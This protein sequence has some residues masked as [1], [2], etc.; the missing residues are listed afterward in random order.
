MS[1][2]SSSPSL[3]WGWR[4]R[5][6]VP[7]AHA[8]L[9][10]GEGARALLARLRVPS[11][12]PLDGLTLCLAHQVLVVIG[13]QASLPWVEGVAYAA[14]CAHDASLWCPTLQEPDV[15]AD[16]L[17][18]ALTRRFQRTPLLLWPQPAAVVPLD[19]QFPAS[20]EVLAQ[21]A[22]RWEALP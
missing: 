16:L 19:R 9:A 5:A 6:E 20:P 21:V 11:E 8:A 18:R 10:W 14:P 15:P 17:A 7:L 3:G 1:L 22:R 12:T 13:P 2:L 4:A